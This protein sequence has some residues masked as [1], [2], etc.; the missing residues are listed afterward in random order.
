MSDKK[1]VND[2]KNWFA[3]HKVLS[4]LGVLVILVIII[5]IVSGGKTD[6]NNSGSNSSDASQNDSSSGSSSEQEDLSQVGKEYILTAGYFTAGIDIPSGDCDVIAVSG[7]GNLSSSN[8]YNG[9]VNEMFG[10]DDGSGY[11]TA[12]FSG[13]KLPEGTVLSLNGDLSVKLIYT[14]IS[15]NFTGRSYNDDSSVTLG[16]GNFTADQDFPAGTYKIVAVSGTGNLSSSN[17][18]DGGVNEMF[19]VDD[20][21]GYYNGQFLN[22]EFDTGVTMTVSGG[23]VVKLI[24][25]E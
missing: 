2:K 1:L 12:S 16:S 18:Y 13:L 19:G 17:I 15:S 5:N 10:I 3:Q 25:A 22:A 20:G 4:I 6:S 7:T 23:L 24:P 21:S 11:Y 8:I 9:G 14:N